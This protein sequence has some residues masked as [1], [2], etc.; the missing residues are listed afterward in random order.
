MVLFLREISDDFLICLYREGNQDAIDL[1]FERYHKFIYGIINDFF[2]TYNCYVDYEEMYQE[3]MCIFLKCLDKYDV[4]NGCFY[5][6]VRTSIERKMKSLYVKM[7]KYSNIISL[8]SSFYIDGKENRLDYVCEED[9]EYNYDDCLNEILAD[10]HKKII[11]LKLKGY[12]YE[13]IAMMLSMSKQ[14]VYRR[15]VKIKNILKDITKN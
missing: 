9:K 13:E 6:F 10:E 11:S 4:D 1:L 5:F 7:K 8:D 3:A 2:K 12:T 14:S 15:I